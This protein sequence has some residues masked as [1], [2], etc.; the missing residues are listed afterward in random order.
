MLIDLIEKY[1]IVLLVENHFNLYFEIVIVLERHIQV[2]L[3]FTLI[4]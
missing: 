1:I 4:F 2:C 3:T